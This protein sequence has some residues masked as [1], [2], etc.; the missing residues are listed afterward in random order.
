MA[1]IKTAP[2]PR[3]HDH[4]F[5]PR[6]IS[7][8]AFNQV[9]WP[10]LPVILVI[11]LLLE[12]ITVSSLGCTAI[13]TL[14]LL[15]TLLNYGYHHSLTTDFSLNNKVAAFEFITHESISHFLILQTHQP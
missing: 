10:Y 11:G 6:K 7:S 3:S 14:T 5:K 2:R 13:I 1:K 4:P 15:Y 12:C 8:R 9:Y